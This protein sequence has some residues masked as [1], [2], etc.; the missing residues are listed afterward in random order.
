VG[1]PVPSAAEGMRATR[2]KM[3]IQERSISMNEF[4]WKQKYKDKTGPATSAMKLIKSG[5]S[6]FIGTGCG[7]PQH[8]VNALVEHSS[9]IYDAHIVHLLTMGTAPYADEK[10]REKF[11]MNSFFI[12]DNV[13]DA[14]AKGIGDYTPIFLSEI[15]FEFETG[16]IPIDVALISVTAPDVNGLCSLGVS[17]D[18]VKS[19]AANAKYVI[20]Q[21]NS[22]MPR[23]FGDSF[24]HVN[25]IDMLVPYDE[26][27]VEIPVPE[28]DETLRRIGQNI[29]R[30]VEDGS[31]IECGIGRI[32][33]A[34]AEFLKDK[35]DLGVHTEMFSD[36]IIDLIE[37][38][39]INC[40]KKSLNR[41]KIVASFCMGSRQLYDYID[42]NPFFEFYPTEYV[43]DINIISQH[44]KM[45]GINVGLEID[46]TGQVCADSLG[47]KF[48]SGIGGQVD[49][50]RGSARSRGGKAIIAMPSTA[51]RGKISRIVPRLTEGSGVVTTRGDVHYVVTEYGIAYLHGK[52][53][54]ERVLDLIHIAHPK[55]RK[56]LIQAAK[57][58]N[59]IY[60]DQIELAWDQVTYPEELERYDTLRDGTEIFFRPIK[61]TDEPAL[62]E[63]MYSLSEKSVQTRYMARTMSFPHRD[64]QRITNIDY[65]QDIAIVGVVPRVSGEEIV[66]IAQYFLD[67]KTQSAEV[68]FLVQDEW[69]R[70]GMGTFLLE[71]ITKIAKQRGVKRFFAKVLP[72]N[73]PML[74]VFYNSGYKVNTEFDGEVYNITYDLK[75]QEQQ[76]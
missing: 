61:P 69:Q 75:M 33:Q 68:A 54:R 39:A 58:Q 7:Q 76:E 72:I 52:S 12:A 23:T 5:N 34:L 42:N 53:I 8:L 9:N 45:V 22:R 71:Y 41:G 49:F 46:L 40:A 10:F 73:K 59:Y 67:P 57:A 63:M 55:F 44:E 13:R 6:I 26:D 66:A 74:A 17:V 37:C 11:K 31:T 27:I 38:G 20:A 35:K 62:S 28:P 14:F 16:R 65:Q 36:W 43:N 21:V 2:S 30:L 15:P 24:I 64:I 4:D 25:A 19:A 29:S 56:E 32:P 51:K 60:E 47:Y 3:G 70:K 48:Y 50:I 1:K 18:I